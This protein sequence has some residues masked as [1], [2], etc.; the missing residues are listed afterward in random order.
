MLIPVLC[1]LQLAAG[2]FIMLSKGTYG[3][4]KP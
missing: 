4:D 2:R 1:A 3:T